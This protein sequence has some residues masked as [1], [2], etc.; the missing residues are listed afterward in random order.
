LQ[1]F[2]RGLL[3]QDQGVADIVRVGQRVG[4]QNFFHAG[5]E[6][7]GPPPGLCRADVPGSRLHVVPEG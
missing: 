4:G 7:D 5:G 2:E 3:Q 1:A 6:P